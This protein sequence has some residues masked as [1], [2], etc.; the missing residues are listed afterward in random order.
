MKKVNF[1]GLNPDDLH[2]CQHCQHAYHDTGM[3]SK[4]CGKSGERISPMDYL[5]T[6]DCELYKSPFL[7]DYRRRVDLERK[8]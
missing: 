1:K 2:T 3:Q 4:V 5:S 7:S 8:L 6:N